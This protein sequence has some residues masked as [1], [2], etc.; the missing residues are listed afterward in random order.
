MTV[1]ELE[2]PQ[3]S[4]GEVTHFHVAATGH[5]LN[6][7]PQYIAQRHG[8]FKEQ[9][10]DITVSVPSPWD[11]VLEELADGT[12]S[13]ALGGIWVP[14][15]YRNTA[16]NYTT[17]AQMSNRCPLALIQR[18]AASA[19]TFQVSD[20]VGKTVLLKSGN[21]AS[22]GLYF[23]MLLR[24]HGVDP[25][26][27]HFVQDLAGPML[28]RLFQGGMG[29]Y[30]LVDI[31]SARAMAKTNPD[32]QVVFEMATGGGDIPWSVYYCETAS[33][34]SP[35]VVDA[36]RR[37]CTALEQGMQYVVQNDA[38]TYWDDLAALFP[39][40]PTDLMVELTNIYR[41]NKMWTS[42]SVSRHGFERWQRGIADGRLTEAP[43]P[44]EEMISNGISAKATNGVHA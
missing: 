26:S 33:T 16:K 35:A 18:G 4:G 41:A 5:S 23:K 24:E 42:S 37:F 39:A 12:A 10:L 34:S 22:I 2:K 19:E 29:N 38:E 9:G 15:M 17:F 25:S 21:G 1:S 27:V 6:Y 31:V 44:Y 11:N 28:S 3:A 32:V 14:S 20:V 7:L 36:Q 40:V 43:I 8:F 30:F 13:A